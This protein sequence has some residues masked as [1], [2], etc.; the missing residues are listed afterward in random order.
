MPCPRTQRHLAQRGIDPATF[1]L[2]AQLPHS[3]AIWLT[4]RSRCLFPPSHSQRWPVGYL[5]FHSMPNWPTEW[6]S[7]ITPRYTAMSSTTSVFHPSPSLAARTPLAPIRVSGASHPSVDV[8]DKQLTSQHLD[9]PY[10]LVVSLL[11]L[12]SAVEVV[13]AVIT[14]KPVLYSRLYL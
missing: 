9:E 5:L 6:S 14:F 1:K 4:L 7:R 11:S 8:G 10:Y 13:V 12:V 3:S 2:L